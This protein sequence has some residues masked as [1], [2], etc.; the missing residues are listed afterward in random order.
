MRACVC[1]ADKAGP[2]TAA[3]VWGHEEVMS[4][5]HIEMPIC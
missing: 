5:M 3:D 1:G 2:K 4:L